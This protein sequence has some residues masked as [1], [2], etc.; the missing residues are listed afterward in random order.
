MQAFIDIQN[1]SS[2]SR[3]EMRE[4]I[5]N[6]AKELEVASEKRIILIY[7]P[8][9][10]LRMYRPVQEQLTRE[11]EKKFAG[12]FILFV[13]KVSLFLIFQKSIYY[14]NFLQRRIIPKPQRGNKK[15]QS[16]LLK[17]AYNYFLRKLKFAYFTLFINAETTALANAVIGARGH[18]QRSRLPVGNRRK[19]SARQARRPKAAQGF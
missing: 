2:V 9:P 3:E 11:L 13:S 14:Y 15:T 5:F 10:Q 19:A 4:L 7:V 8:V 1:S 16:I 12:R 18:S 17:Q 6:A